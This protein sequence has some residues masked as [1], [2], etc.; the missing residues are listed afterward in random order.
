MSSTATALVVVQLL[1]L[2]SVGCPFKERHRIHEFLSCLLQQKDE[3][4]TSSLGFP[5]PC[6]PDE[7][8]NS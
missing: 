1:E 5:Q 7:S 6:R 4:H 8:F 3:V 2:V